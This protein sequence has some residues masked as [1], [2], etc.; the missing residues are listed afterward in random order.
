MPALAEAVPAPAAGDDGR[1]RAVG[2]HA[3]VAA[4]SQVAPPHC[5]RRRGARPSRAL[6]AA[7]GRAAAARAVGSLTH[8]G[9]T[10]PHFPPTPPAEAPPL[11]PLLLTHQCR[12]WPTAA[13]SRA[14]RRVA[15]SEPVPGRA[16][17]VGDALL[18]RVSV[19]LKCDSSRCTHPTNSVH[20]V[21]E[22][23]GDQFRVRRCAASV[24]R[25][26]F[27][28]IAAENLAARP[29]IPPDKGG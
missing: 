17:A 28:R 26:R 20:L 22:R 24:P 8:G 15:R 21:P 2:A 5:R 23:A 29:D 27:F 19:R 18:Q 14:A 4:G 9:A 12:V 6:A 3:S 13:T 25:A 16:R 1:G 10:R 7:A 11:A